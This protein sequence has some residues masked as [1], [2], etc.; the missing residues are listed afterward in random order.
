LHSKAMHS[1][2][3]DKAYSHTKFDDIAKPLAPFWN[4]LVGT[5]LLVYV[6]GCNVVP[7]PGKPDNV[8]A[9]L[10]IGFCLVVLVFLGGHIS[11]AHY[12]P[13]VTIGILL[14]M[15]SKISTMKSLGYIAVQ[16]IGSFLGALMV[17]TTTDGSTFGPMINPAYNLGDGL[18]AEIMATFTLVSVVLNVATTE[19]D[20]GNSFFGLAIGLTV[21]SMGIAVGGISGGAFN[22]AV[23]TGPLLVRWMFTGQYYGD[24][25]VYWAGP[26]LGA[27]LAAVLFRVT[28]IAEYARQE[29]AARLEQTKMLLREGLEH[30][31]I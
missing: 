4:E 14:T 31:S 20:A 15:R 8:L 22:P 25:W 27:A 16:L 13:A 30:G 6:I 7:H 5:M 26:L 10:S 12:N 28:N 18:I 2:N 24:G 3:K 11:G 9:P 1:I 29:E 17:Y 23:G 19:E 21:A